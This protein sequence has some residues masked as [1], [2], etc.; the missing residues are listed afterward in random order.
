MPNNEE[1]IVVSSEANLSVLFEQHRLKALK[2]TSKL[3]WNLHC[4]DPSYFSILLRENIN[5]YHCLNLV[6]TLT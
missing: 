4:V 6:T 5:G 3:T 2:Q 1:G